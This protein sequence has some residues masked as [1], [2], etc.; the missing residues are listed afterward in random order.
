MPAAI[1]PTRPVPAR[2]VDFVGRPQGFAGY[3]LGIGQPVLLMT[4]RVRAADATLLSRFDAV[5]SRALGSACEVAAV[6]DAPPALGCVLRWSRVLLDGAGHPAFV[7][8]R[9][10]GRRQGPPEVR[11]VALPCLLPDAALRGVAFVMSALNR[12]LVGG[13][14]AADGESGLEAEIGR[15]SKFLARSGLQGF[16]PF[17]FLQAAHDLGIPW[18]RLVGNVIQLGQGSRARWL[19]SSFTDATPKIASQLARNK[20][21]AAVVLRLAGIPVP[22]HAPVRSAD[23]AERAATAL[24]YPVVVKPADLDGGKAVA[25]HLMEAQAVRKAF[26]AARAVSRQILVEK[27]VA[28]RDFRV[29]VVQGEVQGVLERIPGGVTGN[30]HDT[31]RILLERQNEERRTATDDRR[32]LHQMA[33]DDEAAEL[34]A[35]H[36]MTWESVPDDGR[37][38]RMRGAANV[39]N[40]GVPV[41][42]P[43]EQVHPDNLL[44]ARRAAQALRLDVAGIDL[45]IPDIDR[46]WLDSGAFICEVNAQPQMFSTFHR[47]MVRSIVK[48]DG[49]VPVVVCLGRAVDWNMAAGLHHRLVTMGIS[50]GLTSPA[51]VW[52]GARC[53]AGP[54][55]GA[56]AGGRMLLHDPAVEAMVIHVADDAILR[57]GW[58][59]DRCDVLVVHGSDADMAE[60]PASVFRRF[61]EVARDVAPK[62]VFLDGC[63]EAVVALVQRLFGESPGVEQ[64]ASGP[65]I[66]EEVARRICDVLTTCST[67]RN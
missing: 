24:G 26:V 51:G 34:L 31:V 56:F 61:V 39:T 10:L 33:F 25:A 20:Q 35:A 54:H 65:A 7:P 27:H 38:V 55:H 2:T 6:A 17:H 28:G 4:V 30:G 40:G 47:P 32:Y 60:P 1:S 36:A 64:I 59:V 5:W 58:P 67:P 49:R 19:D 3:A 14:R 44:L 50:A 45:L 63:A 23:D 9:M 46:S 22:P 15:M 11:A 16:N 41:P 43:L 21:H 66:G 29:Q 53:V 8:P 57:H 42:V 52:V 48:G 13:H 12:W 37:F 18:L 62:A